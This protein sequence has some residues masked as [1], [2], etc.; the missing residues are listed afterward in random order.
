MNITQNHII[1]GILFRG[2]IIGTV[3]EGKKQKKGLFDDELTDIQFIESIIGSFEDWKEVKTKINNLAGITHDSKPN[4]AEA[5][6]H[7]TI[8]K[9]SF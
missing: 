4:R 3:Q 9:M 6:D 8:M 7:D 2:I 1:N 5:S